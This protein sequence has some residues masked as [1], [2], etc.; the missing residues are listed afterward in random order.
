MIG[1]IEFANETVADEVFIPLMDGSLIKFD[2]SGTVEVSISQFNLM[3]DNCIQRERLEIV[4]Q[5]PQGPVHYHWPNQN[6]C[7]SNRSQIRQDHL[8]NRT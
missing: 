5:L 7:H 8:I 4:Q 1:A 2:K 6:I 3:S